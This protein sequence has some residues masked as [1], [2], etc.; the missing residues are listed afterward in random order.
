[1]TGLILNFKG[2]PPSKDVYKNNIKPQEKLFFFFL[3]SLSMQPQPLRSLETQASF[4]NPNL[5]QKH[6]QWTALSRLS[7]LSA[8]ELPVDWSLVDRT[9]PSMQEAL[10]P[11]RGISYLRYYGAF[12]YPSSKGGR[13]NRGSRPC[14]AA[15]SAWGQ[16]RLHATPTQKK[17]RKNSN[18]NQLK[19]SLTRTKSDLRLRYSHCTYCVLL[20]WWTSG[21]QR[22]QHDCGMTVID[23]GGSSGR[24]SSS[25]SPFGSRRPASLHHSAHEEHSN[26]K[27]RPTC[28]SSRK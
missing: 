15:L 8:M 10:R 27:Q 19:A 4:R 17:R 2:K 14:S 12:L 11:R 7:C 22:S 18:K 13:R 24:R 5:L 23:G 20:P 3:K 26:R 1:M 16:P 6:L 28:F 25:D 9:L 21:L